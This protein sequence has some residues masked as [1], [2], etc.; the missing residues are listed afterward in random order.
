MKHTYSPKNFGQ[1]IGRTTSILQKMESLGIL[2][3]WRS[4]TDLCYYTHDQY[5]KLLEKKIKK[6]QNSILLPSV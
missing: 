4:P 6:L 1:L 5:E 2:K 3:A